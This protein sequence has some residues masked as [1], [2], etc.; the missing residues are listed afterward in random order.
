MSETIFK[1]KIAVH[2]WLED[3]GWQISKSQFYDHCKDGLLRPDKKDGK[4]RLKAVEKYAVLHVKKAETG[5]KVNDLEEQIRQQK[6]EISLERE[7]IGLDREKF[8]QQ[9]RL[10][11]FVARADFEMAIVARAVTFM[12]H[13]NHSIQSSVPDWIDIVEGDQL[14]APELVDAIIKTIEQRMGDFAVDAEFDVILEA[15]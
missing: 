5:Q 12:A 9:K 4:Y 10:G 14:R 15:N 11:K 13:L 6:L 7:R 2:R 3:N 1:S 8:D